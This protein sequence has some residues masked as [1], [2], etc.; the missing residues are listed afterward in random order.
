MSWGR[1]MGRMQTLCL[2]AQTLRWS[3]HSA[4]V[5]RARKA[6]QL[7]AAGVVAV[8]SLGTAPVGTGIFCLYLSS[9]QILH[10]TAGMDK[11]L[12][13]FWSGLRDTEGEF[14]GTLLDPNMFAI[15]VK[16]W[17]EHDAF[18]EACLKHPQLLRLSPP[19]GGGPE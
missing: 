18:E 13:R 11:L 4:S 3:R 15:D 1:R 14:R 10:P 19:A 17:G 8:K 12:D 6:T 16:E 7:A 9:A 5:P 2:A